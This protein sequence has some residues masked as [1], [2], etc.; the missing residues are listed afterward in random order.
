MTF[1]NN[2][3]SKYVYD[4]LYPALTA[5]SMLEWQA[6]IGPTKFPAWGA[7]QTIPEY[8]WNLQQAIGTHQSVFHSNAIDLEDYTDDSFVIGMNLSKVQSDDGSDN[9]SSLSTRQGD[10]LSFRTRNLN[11]GITEAW[12]FLQYSM[13]LTVSEEGCAVFD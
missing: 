9:M 3:T 2:A 5:N 11:T 6:Q 12:I 1:S 8:Y 4:M 10:L 7:L 13:L